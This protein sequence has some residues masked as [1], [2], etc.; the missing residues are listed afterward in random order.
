[1][2][3]WHMLQGVLT[4]NNGE[5]LSHFGAVSV[6][7]KAAE[8]SRPRRF[9][10]LAY[11]GGTLPVDGFPLPVV[12]DLQGLEASGSIPI[13]IDHKNSVETSLGSTDAIINDGSQLILAGP[14]QNQ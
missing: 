7:L 2:E 5:K 1:M 11:S 8:G 9:E 3:E 6:E 10:I 4:A 13:L 14:A 12:V